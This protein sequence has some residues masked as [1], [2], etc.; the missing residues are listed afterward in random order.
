MV[1][2]H[3]VRQAVTRLH[4]L[5][6]AVTRL[7]LKGAAPAAATWSSGPPGEPRGVRHMALGT[8]SRS[9]RGLGALRCCS[10]RRTSG[11]G[12]G[13]FHVRLGSG[14]RAKCLLRWSMRNGRRT[15]R[16][17]A[18]AQPPLPGNIPNTGNPHQFGQ[19]L[20]ILS[21]A[22]QKAWSVH[23]MEMRAGATKNPTGIDAMEV[24]SKESKE[25]T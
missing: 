16:S 19:G 11:R 24:R 25:H 22:W 5:Q 7:P 2:P 14:A 3:E 9:G 4:D 17:W 20:V 10:P 1:G 21:P 13:G 18:P 8:S 12:S 15:C 6:Q 23:S